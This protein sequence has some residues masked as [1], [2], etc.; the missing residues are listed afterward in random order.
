MNL[1]Y[2]NWDL[3]FGRLQAIKTKQDKKAK[4]KT[5]KDTQKLCRTICRHTL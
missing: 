3:E 5:K 1:L 2:Y 4:N